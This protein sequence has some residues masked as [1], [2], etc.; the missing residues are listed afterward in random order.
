MSLTEIFKKVE[1]ST[2][3][4]DQAA[5]NQKIKNSLFSFVQNVILLQD[6]ED[7]NK[8]Y[9][10]IECMKTSSYNELDPYLK[11]QIRD[12]YIEYP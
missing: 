7:P 6:D 12:L 2:V 3:T 9:P 4:A 1:S 8:F 10:R 11:D 5:A